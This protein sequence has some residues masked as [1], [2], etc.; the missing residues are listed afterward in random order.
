MIVDSYYLSQPGMLKKTTEITELSE[1]EIIYMVGKFTKR[2]HRAGKYRGEV[3]ITVKDEVIIRH[4]FTKKII[5]R[6]YL[7]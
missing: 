4:H 1:D 7:K 2:S 3:L 5:W 6:G